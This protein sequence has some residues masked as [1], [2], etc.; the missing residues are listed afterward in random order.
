MNDLI[1][2]L[3]VVSP[4][5]LL[6]VLGMSLRYFKLID[7]NFV[8]ITS[9]FVFNISLPV[10]VFM[11]L[12]RVDLS[13]TFDLTF[14]AF[15]FISTIILFLFNWLV[16]ILI[17]SSRH[18][19]GVFIQGASRSNF[20]IVGLA[21]I[22]GMFGQPSL[23]KAS[24]LIPFLI[25]L[26]NF[27]SILALTYYNN[28]NLKMGFGRLMKDVFLNP[29]ILGVV[30]ALPFA[31]WNI[32]IPDAFKTTGNYLSDMAL[33][34]ALIGIGG[35]LNIDAVKESS[36]ISSVASIIKIV[37]AP[38]IITLISIWLGFTGTDVGIIFVVFGC[39]TAIVS[40]V[41]AVAMGGSAKIAGNIIVISTLGS[42]VTYTIGL[43]ALRM[44]NF[45]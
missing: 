33:P 12:Y 1:Y 44:L 10:L 41:M 37:V 5:F 27:S 43:Y 23:V 45:F 17:V 19:R 24:L 18:D 11:K 34:L 32:N 22:L 38:L 2:I 31:M 6:V 3:N 30:A 35:S 16:S 4:V 7:D 39:P 29:L 36:Y 15:I 21:I 14:V 25:P 8:K 13:A 26:Y 28:R 40:F 9:T 20:A 42:V